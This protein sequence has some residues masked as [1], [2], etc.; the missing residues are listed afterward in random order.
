MPLL[1]LQ[2]SVPVP[3]SKKASLLKSCSSILAEAT[4]KPEKYVMVLLAHAD[5]A[6]MGGKPLAAAFVDVRGIGGLYDAINGRISKG[7]CDLLKQ[8][9]QID[10]Q[11]VYL[12]F[13]DVPG[14]NW[15]WNGTTFDR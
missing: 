12:N 10:P 7:V 9:L 15:G 11:N 1:K 3:D 14:Q 6:C 13:T 2:V 8:E 4:G 5:G